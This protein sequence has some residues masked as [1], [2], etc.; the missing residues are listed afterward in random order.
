MAGLGA[1]IKH[2]WNSF[3]SSEEAPE[4]GYQYGPSYVTSGR[5]DRPRFRPNSER[6][7]ISS[8]YTRLSIDVAG[9]RIEHCRVDENGQY[10]DKID[11]GLNNC[12]N[13][14]ANI[15]QGGRHFRQ[16]MALSLFQEG[17]I[18]IVP[19]DTTL[20]PTN[21]GNWDIKTMRVGTIC[22]WYPQHVKIRAYNEKSGKQE[23][24]ILPKSTVAIVENP[25]YSVMNES[26][27]TLQRL[28]HK[29]S[30][31]DH[32]DEISSSGKLDIIIQLP[33]VVKTESKRTQ[34][35]NRRKE[36]EDQL[37]GST[38]GIAY[39]DGTEKITQLNRAVENNLLEQVKY[40]KTE[41]YNE[42]GLTEGIMNGTAD[43]VEMLNYTNRFIEP[44]MDALVE[45]MLRR[46][47]TK[48]ARTQG[49]SILYFQT[50]F[51]LLP[52]SE[53]ANIADVLS[54][55]Q[56]VTPNEFRPVLGLK[57]SKEP[58]ANRLVN[59]NMPLKDQITGPADPAAVDTPPGGD[60]SS[61]DGQP[62]D[63]A[64]IDEARLNQQ[65]A[66]LGLA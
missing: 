31:L 3:V 45:A 34:A 56:I 5:P 25:F 64:A 30:L 46:F 49:Q 62:A 6:T 53:L 15:D 27:S 17:V 9:V 26:N 66:E 24:I 65:M 51:K 61:T 50:P 60:S 11:S 28:I 55:N 38:Y 29:L 54:R 32:V 4:L 40:L 39:T 20:D 36:L 44:V 19:V 10:V 52:I 33:Y 57:P 12:L 47:L 16:D 43:D 63:Q 22:Q 1:R 42:L 13:V 59:S 37:S 48:T 21:S 58:Q 41:L 7:I 18:A 2:A 35:Q 23:E 8:I 14:E